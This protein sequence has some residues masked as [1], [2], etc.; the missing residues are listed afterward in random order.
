[1]SDELEL[2]FNKDVPVVPEVEFDYKKMLQNCKTGKEKHN[3][4]LFKHIIY[5]CFCLVLCF[6][7]VL[8]TVLI[9]NNNSPIRYAN[10]A[11][12]DKG[13]SPY[14]SRIG[15]SQELYENRKKE[16][17]D[18]EPIFDKT[19]A[20]GPE[21]ASGMIKYDVISKSNLLNEEDKAVLLEYK[22]S[23]N[24]KYPNHEVSFQIAFGIKNN[25]DYIYLIDYLGYDIELEKEINNTFLF[26]SNLP[27]SFESI[28]NRSELLLNMELTDEFLNSSYYDGQN[29][30]ASGIIIGFVENDGFFQEYYMVKLNE[31]ISTFTMNGDYNKEKIDVIKYES[32]TGDIY[33]ANIPNPDN[34]NEQIIEWYGIEIN[35][36]CDYSKHPKYKEW[37]EEFYNGNYQTDPYDTRPLDYHLINFLHKKIYE[38]ESMDVLFSNQQT[39]S[40]W[41]GSQIINID[42]MAKKGNSET[43]EEAVRNMEEYLKDF[44]ETDDYNNLLELANKDY[45]TKI[46]IIERWP[47]INGDEQSDLII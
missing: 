33:D 38:Y 24:Q 32:T 10:P 12:V 13:K 37:E 22:T 25:K 6:I 15:Y 41:P 18:W 29:L 28:V 17:P 9:L 40:F 16:N 3:I 44:Y 30:L 4:K 5:A 26:E 23:V 34:P 19:I 43:M 45:I 36:R 20:W 42:Y 31:R 2:L 8:T 21:L 7:S 11:N 27:Y 35:I 46:V 14:L 39:H 47:R 1:M